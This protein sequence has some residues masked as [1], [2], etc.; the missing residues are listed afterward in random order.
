VPGA[1]GEAARQPAVAGPFEPGDA[2]TAVRPAVQV[3]ADR[4]AAVLVHHEPG[5]R[6]P[7][8]TALA[9]RYNVST[10]QLDEAISE[11]IGRHLI[12]RLPD[13]QVYRISP[14]EY[15]VSLE[16]VA[17]LSS[18]LDPMGGELTCRSRHTSWRRVPEDIGW[19]L[20]VSP[21]GQ[22]CV[23]RLLWAA[24]GE[25]AACATTYLPP[26]QAARITATGPDAD[27][28]GALGPLPLAAAGGQPVPGTGGVSAG[29]PAA[30][31]LEMQ[32]PPP[33]VAR[34]LRLSAGQPAAIVTIR[35][36]DRDSGH[37]SALAVTVLRPDMF[38][39]VVSSGTG[40]LPGGGDGRPGLT[41]SGAW[42]HAVEDWES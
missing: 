41:F 12:R 31:H 17:G 36:D 34:S 30:L 24:G 37:P 6:L 9:R 27:D 39:I 22:V 23:V 8:H 16:G 3:L 20:G 18:Q 11:L 25:P 40:R 1:S 29:R 26:A 15:I 38:R 14:A 5:W 28:A 42:T 4:L 35:F 13:G 2:L 10:A 19:V 21:A 7:R 32:P 33:A